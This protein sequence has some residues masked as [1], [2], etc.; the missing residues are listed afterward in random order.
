MAHYPEA[1]ERLIQAFTVLPGVGRK[2]AERYVLHLLRQP[3]AVVQSIA[4]GL[5]D[6]QNII[7]DCETCFNITTEVHCDICRSSQRDQ[8]I[9]C[10]VSDSS[11]IQALEQTGDFN[12]VYHVLGGTVNQLEGIGPE[13]LHIKELITRLEQSPAITEVV[14][15]TNPNV[16]GETTALYVTDALK[17]TTVRIT[18]LAR[19]L[20]AGSDIQYADDVTLGNALKDRKQI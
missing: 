2:T 19:G 17:G 12:G 10:V 1:I 14:I 13:Q 9:I 15:A 7:R 11:S 16:A 20:P 5:Q 4:L 8:S 18:R 6:V 3:P